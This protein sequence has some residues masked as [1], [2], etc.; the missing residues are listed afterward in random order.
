MYI[1]IYTYIYILHTYIC[2][3]Q[4]L[5]VDTHRDCIYF[6]ILYMHTLG[7]PIYSFS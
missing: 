4:V 6:Q 1:Y 7:V 2:V 5:N 3:G